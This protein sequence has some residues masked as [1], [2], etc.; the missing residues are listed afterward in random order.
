VGLAIAVVLTA[1]APALGRSTASA[2]GV[3]GLPDLTFYGRGYGHGVGMS[4]YGA[5][6]RVLAG[7]LAPAILAHNYPKTTLGTRS[8]TTPV[9][10]LLLT[11]FKA[12]A[13]KPLTVVGSLGGWTIDGLTDPFPANA[14]LTL[15][16]TAAG[17]T[18]WN[19]TVAS[20]TGAVLA[21]KVVSGD[22]RVR[23]VSTASLLQLVSKTAT[24]NVYRGFFRIKLTTTAAVVNHIGLDAYLRGVVPLEMPASWPAEALKAQAIT[25]RT[26]AIT[27][28]KSADFDHYA[29][30][31]SQV[32]RGVGIETAATN[33]AVADTR[34]QV[35]TYNG[36]PVVTYFFSTSGGRTEA[37][38]NTTLGNA[39]KP[40]LQSVDDEFDSV[41]PRHRWTTKLTMKSAARKL[42]GLVKGSF[43]GIR[44]TKRGASPRIMTA[45]VVG[46]RGVTTTDGATLRARLGLFDTW[47]FFTAIK[48]S[49]ETAPEGDPS[50]GA[51][52]P[53]R[54]FSYLHRRV[55]G[56]LRGSVVGPRGR[57]TLRVQLRRGTAWADVGTVRT[58][59]GGTYR[60]RASEPGTY[61]VVV[62]GAFGPA[63]ALG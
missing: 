52:I 63:V 12:T 18:T 23:P 20:S 55:A 30:T 43:K 34:G 5:R 42:G 60:W 57:A 61:R 10:V 40:W 26:Y 37:V 11:G 45:E 3:P 2:D 19:L 35:V 28:A 32:Y 49:K 8:A 16:P 17:A 14:R 47:A 41:S 13:A 29:D 22:V 27:T 53:P 38:E 33:A 51:T 54:S 46:S 48:G 59:R 39:P 25:A 21:A 15:A 58:S 24:A 1:L 44:V 36:Q 56:V 50:G 9:R 6:G 31:R 4:Q 62:A 7:H